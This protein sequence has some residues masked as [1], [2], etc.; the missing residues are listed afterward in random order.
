MIRTFAALTLAATLLA[1]CA[2][3]QG[4]RTANERFFRAIGE[5]A[6][7]SDVIAA[8]LAFARMA[9]EEGQWKAFRKFAADDALIFG[10]NGAFEAKP[11]LRQ[12]E[13]PAEAVQWEP[14]AVW[15][16]CDGSLAVTTGVF[17]DPDGRTGRF[18]TVWERQRRGDYL[19]VFDF[20]FETD[21]VPEEPEMIASKVAEC[22]KPATVVAEPSRSIRTSR[23]GTL[24]WTFHFGEDRTRTFTVWQEGM[25]GTTRVLD[26]AA[27]ATPAT[28]P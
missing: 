18:H 11:W 4:P 6:Q 21:D 9:R 14:Y 20:G 2:P 22:G 23:D 15:A 27:P 10:P 25:E 13:E 17:V 12:Q 26:V 19:Y 24:A 5:K 28:Q 8:E 16:S 3:N 7:P 1:A